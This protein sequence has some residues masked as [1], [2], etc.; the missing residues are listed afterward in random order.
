MAFPSAVDVALSEE[1]PNSFSTHGTVHNGILISMRAKHEFW[2]QAMLLSK[3]RLASYDPVSMDTQQ[4]VFKTTGP[5]MLAHAFHQAQMVQQK[6]DV[7][8]LPSHHFCSY[9]HGNN[10]V[11]S[12]TLHHPAHAIPLNVATHVTTHNESRAQLASAGVVLLLIA[13]KS[14]WK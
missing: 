6:H 12:K 11:Y 14:T 2:M 8:L 9:M 13:N 5:S 7:L 4:Y 1:W 10:I 3:Q